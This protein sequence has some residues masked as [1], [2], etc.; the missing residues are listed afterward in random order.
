VADVGGWTAVRTEVDQIM[1]SGGKVSGVRLSD[2]REIQSSKVISAV[3]G[4]LTSN[5]VKGG[6]GTT[7]DE[8][9]AGPAHVSLYLGFEG[10]IESA[11]ASTYSQWFFETWDME[12]GLWPVKPG[13]KPS[14]A[15]VLYCSW[16]S[17][18]DPAHDPGTEMR[19]TG[20]IITFVPWESFEP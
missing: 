7:D 2:G 16:P 11:G 3:G 15:D 8:F 17:L 5:L 14:R 4:P 9:P 10:D 6:A 18:K 19:H 13:E 20:E 1:L 12:Q